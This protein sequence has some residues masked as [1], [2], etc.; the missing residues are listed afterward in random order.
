MQYSD[1]ADAVYRAPMPGGVER[2]LTYGLCGMSVTD[3]RSLRRVA[4]FEKV[5]EQAVPSA[6]LRT[7]ARGGRNFQQTHDPRVGAESAS[8]WR[9]RNH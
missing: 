9:A 6:T 4:C 5:P 3:E 1:P 2:A 7:F 8:V